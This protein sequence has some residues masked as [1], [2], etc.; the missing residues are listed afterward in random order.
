MTF[1]QFTEH[2]QT[3]HHRDWIAGETTGLENLLTQVPQACL[4]GDNLIHDLAIAAV[5]ANGKASADD[6]AQANQVRRDP[7]ILGRATQSQGGSWSPLRRRS[8]GFHI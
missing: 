4:G 1:F 5:A 3:R 8:A 6:L 2:S 7:E